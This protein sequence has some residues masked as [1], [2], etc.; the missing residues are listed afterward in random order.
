MIRSISVIGLGYVG[1]PT[2]ILFAQKKINVQGVDIDQD[3]IENLKK[4][5][6][7]INESDFIKIF[8]NDIVRK[9]ISF[10][11]KIEFNTDAYIICVPTPVDK[12]KKPN[13]NF[14]ISAINSLKNFLKR[15]D[16]IIIEST[17]PLHAIDKIENIL[18]EKNKLNINIVYCPERVFPG[19]TLKELIHN[20]RIIGL[21]NRKISIINDLYKKI[22]KGNISYTDLKSAILIK[23]LE[24]TYRD[25]QIAFA[26]QARLLCE[27]LRVDY[28]NVISLA[29]NHPRV[30]ILNPGI[31]VG[32]HCIPVDPHFIFNFKNTKLFKEARF[33]NNSITRLIIK[34]LK[35]LLE[36][37]SIKKI[38]ILG[39]SY[40][41]NIGDFRESPALKIIDKLS[42]KF[43]VRYYDPYIDNFMKNKKNL[44]KLYLDKSNILNFSKTIIILTNHKLFENF[45]FK[46]DHLIINPSRDT[47]NIEE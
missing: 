28:K 17:I 16:H 11:N 5:N 22:I 21:N 46:N 39:L 14:L 2:A 44:K 27:E 41:E 42:K 47:L 18:K 30:N 35:Y 19:N 12:D 25:N 26:N 3:L 10:S 1:L 34:K 29:N 24:N 33:L 7:Q 31:G 4:K 45:P 40:K 8:K 9:Y 36:K 13:L 32:G 43:Q 15:N 20:D 6:T 23:L 37:K 38:S